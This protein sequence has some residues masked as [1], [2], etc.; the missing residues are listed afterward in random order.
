[1]DITTLRHDFPI[2]EQSYNN[3]KL[4]YLDNGA[5]TQ[6]PLCVIDSISNYYKTINSNVHRSVHILGELSTTSMEEARDTV[7]KFINAKD[8]HSVIF[9]KGTTESINL[10][11]DSFMKYFVN[12]GDSV[13]VSV[14]EHHSNFVPWQQKCIEKNAKFKIVP[15]TTTGELDVDAFEQMLDENVKLVAITHIS[16]VLGTVNDVK[17]IVAKAHSVGAKVLIDGAQSIAHIPIDVQ[18]IDCDFYVFSGHKIYANMGIGVLYGK[19]DILEQMPPYQYGGEMIDKVSIEK[20]TFNVLP[21]KYEAGTPNVE[22]II[23]LKT[24]LDY[25]TNNDKQS[26]FDYEDKLL[27]YAI[28][29]LQMLY[30]IDILGGC[31]NRKAVISFNIKGQHHYDVGTLLNQLNIAVRTGTHCAEPLM[32]FYGITGCVRAS[33]AFYN[34]FEEIDILIEGLKKVHKMLL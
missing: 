10:V 13:V 14:M 23:G 16:N 20:T 28:K 31:E 12:K 27:N 26:L 25:L 32:S 19:I 29:S 24:A 5:T 6:K 34:T 22:G 17:K 33:L 3:K 7:A 9:T 15:L 8:R 1:M 18:D 4:V 2:L 11:A 30:F 21:Y